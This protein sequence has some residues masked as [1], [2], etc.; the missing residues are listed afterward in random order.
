MNTGYI[1]SSTRLRTLTESLLQ[2]GDVERLLT[3]DSEEMFVQ[4]LRDSYLGHYISDRENS[5]ESVYT[6][7]ESYKRS[8]RSLIEQIVPTSRLL[9]IIWL[10]GDFHNLRVFVK[11]RTMNFGYEETVRHFVSTGVYQPDNF[12]QHALDDTLNRL[13]PELHVAHHQAVRLTEQK[14]F[15]QADSVIDTAYWQ[16]I[17][18]VAK[19][20]NDPFVSSYVKY[21]IDIYNIKARLRVDAVDAYDFDAI[22]V[23]GGSIGRPQLES[24]TQA[25]QALSQYG[26]EALW[27]DAITLWQETGEYTALENIDYL[28]QVRMVEQASYDVFSTASLYKYVLKMQQS[29]ALVRTILVGLSTQREVAEIRS[30]L[31]FDYDLNS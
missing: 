30:L 29:N 13:E 31:P 15:A 3:A 4:L 9:D 27:R 20:L 10:R 2:S 14:L 16:T 7:I 5:A 18:R 28:Y 23:S 26:G 25:V 6:A 17:T 1:Y 19:Q 24:A 11:A 8:A 21:L 12:Y 22:F